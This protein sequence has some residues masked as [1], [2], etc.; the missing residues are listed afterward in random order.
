MQ[1]SSSMNGSGL[2]QMA[3]PALNLIIVLDISGRMWG[4]SDP[5]KSKLCVAKR[6]IHAIM[7]QLGEA[8]RLG[9][10]LF[11]H[12]QKTLLPLTQLGSISAAKMQ[13]LRG[14]IDGLR[15]CGG[16]NLQAGFEAGMEVLDCEEV[17]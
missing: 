8:D 10:I 9:I 7:A 15:P 6:C 1:V 17:L 12:S 2:Q 13:R 3:R 11:D 16:T 14:Q 4:C 5:S